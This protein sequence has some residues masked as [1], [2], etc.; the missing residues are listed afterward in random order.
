MS[1]LKNENI[2]KM[3]DAVPI[4]SSMFILLIKKNRKAQKSK[5][6]RLILKLIKLFDFKKFFLLFIK[7]FLYFIKQEFQFILIIV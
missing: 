7:Q 3:E 2:P 1:I 4:I 6:A 5:T